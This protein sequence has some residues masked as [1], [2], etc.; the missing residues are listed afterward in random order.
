MPSLIS[1]WFM[2]LVNLLFS[3]VGLIA[4]A[5]LFGLPLLFF[6]A[7]LGLKMSS[8]AAILIYSSPIWAPFGA[9]AGLWV[10]SRLAKGIRAALP[11]TSA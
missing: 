11:E 4:A 1:F 10:A 7:T 9:G 6:S 2:G 8:V 5:S 3:A